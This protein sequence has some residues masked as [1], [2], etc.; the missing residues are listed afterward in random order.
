MCNLNI[1]NRI[2][3]FC[4]I[5]FL[6]RGDCEWLLAWPPLWL[7]LCCHLHVAYS[8]QWRRRPV[9]IERSQ[10]HLGKRN[11]EKLIIGDIRIRKLDFPLVVLNVI[12]VCLKHTYAHAQCHSRSS[13][14]FM[15]LVAVYITVNRSINN[16]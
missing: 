1:V 8:K 6:L 9:S 4:L 5:F 13:N 7:R 16:L 10:R 3:C 15:L 14:L 2:S 12:L 11:E